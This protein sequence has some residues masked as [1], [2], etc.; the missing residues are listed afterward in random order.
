MDRPVAMKSNLHSVLFETTTG[1]FWVANADKEGNPAAEQPYH[2]FQLPDLLTHQADAS[3][4]ALPFEVKQTAGCPLSRGA[5]R[6][7]RCASGRGRRSLPVN[8][9]TARSGCRGT[10]SNG[11]SSGSASSPRTPRAGFGGCWAGR[12]GWAATRPTARSPCW[13]LHQGRVTVAIVQESTCLTVLTWNQF[14]PRLGEF[15]RPKTPRKWGRLL[16]RLA[17]PLEKEKPS[18]PPSDDRDRD[19]DR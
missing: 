17:T 9:T 18:P 4:P 13:A 5:D 3:A 11:S 15:G 6:S 8:A 16:D 1:R 2:A 10:R 14:E 7:L 19:R 12:A